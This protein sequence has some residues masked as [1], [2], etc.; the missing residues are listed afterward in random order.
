[1]LRE[2]CRRTALIRPTAHAPTTHLEEEKEKPTIKMYV[3]T[4]DA[5]GA[6]CRGARWKDECGV[7]M[8]VVAAPTVDHMLT[9]AIGL[10]KVVADHIPIYRSHTYI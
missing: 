3:V 7:G 1:M 5:T 6:F 4:P 8:P 2:D 10:A 9:A